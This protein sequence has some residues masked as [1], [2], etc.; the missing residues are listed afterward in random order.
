MQTTR[1]TA[2]IKHQ[3][4]VDIW[5]CFTYHRSERSVGGGQIRKTEISQQHAEA[6]AKGRTKPR[7]RTQLHSKQQ[8]S[9]EGEPTENNQ[10][11]KYIGHQIIARLF[12]YQQKSR[13]K[14]LWMHTTPRHCHRRERRL[15][16]LKNLNIFKKQIN[17][18][19]HFEFN[20][21]QS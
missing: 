14:K 15:L 2:T 13:T 16:T 8:P 4:L 6:S 17:K 10:K 9:H 5:S 3:Q 1:K 20:N 12:N 18:S 11:H 7:K 19:A 21:K